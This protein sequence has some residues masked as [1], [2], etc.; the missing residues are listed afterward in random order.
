MPADVLESAFRLSLTKFFPGTGKSFDDEV[1]GG[2]SCVLNSRYEGADELLNA[3]RRISS[4]VR[5]S[6]FCCG[7]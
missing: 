1:D 4:S 5:K 2:D 3:K 7:A 6:V